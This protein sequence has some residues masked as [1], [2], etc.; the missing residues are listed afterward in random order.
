MTGVRGT[1]GATTVLLERPLAAPLTLLTRAPLERPLTA[2]VLFT[3]VLLFGRTVLDFFGR[4]VLAFLCLVF[5]GAA[6]TSTKFKGLIIKD[7]PT[8]GTIARRDK[9]RTKNL[10]LG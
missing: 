7:N 1:T 5:L 2:L 10:Y 8:K 6:S 3:R 4:A 9:T